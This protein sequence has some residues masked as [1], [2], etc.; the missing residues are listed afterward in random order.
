MYIVEFSMI[1][2]ICLLFINNVGDMQVFKELYVIELLYHLT[3]LA[4]NTKS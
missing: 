1:L 2:F 3:M 4:P